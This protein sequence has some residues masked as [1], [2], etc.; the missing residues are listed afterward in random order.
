MRRRRTECPSPASTTSGT[1]VG[2]RREGGGEGGEMGRPQEPGRRR[3]GAPKLR[4]RCQGAG[5]TRLPERSR[6]AFRA[7][8][9]YGYGRDAEQG[10]KARGRGRSREVR[11]VGRCPR[12]V[13][14]P[15]RR[16]GENPGKEEEEPPEAAHAKGI[17]PC[18]VNVNAPARGSPPEQLRDSAPIGD[19][20]PSL[21]RRSEIRPALAIGDSARVG[22][23]GLNPRRRSAARLRRSWS[24]SHARSRGR[25][26]SHH[27]GR[28]CGSRPGSPARSRRREA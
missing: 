5:A 8:I 19:P 15:A 2:R 21:R 23:P 18:P 13:R 20:A 16:G 1:D 12:N 17:A 11:G 24:G 9:G 28:C 22:V 6:R 10:Q 25:H 27:T 3:G 26:T 14:R 4:P 7:S